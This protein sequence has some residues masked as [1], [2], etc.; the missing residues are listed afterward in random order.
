MLIKIPSTT[1]INSSYALYNIEFYEDEKL[2]D[3]KVLRMSKRFSDF[4]EFKKNLENSVSKRIDAEFPS[5]LYF[6]SSIDSQ[7]LEDRRVQLENFLNHILNDTAL[8]NNDILRNFLNLPYSSLISF[9]PGE[10]LNERSKSL[11][12]HSWNTIYDD[13]VN[14]NMKNLSAKEWLDMVRDVKLLIQ[15]CRSKLFENMNDNSSDTDSNNLNNIK[16]TSNLKLVECRK[17]LAAI[18]FR[19]EILNKNLNNPNFK[20]QLGKG[21]VIRRQDLF[22]SLNRDY[23]DMNALLVSISTN[24]K[25]TKDNN[26]MNASSNGDKSDRSNL[27]SSSTRPSRRTL[28]KPRETEVTKTMDNSELHQY[29]QQ[30]MQS[31]DEDLIV[32]RK[33]IERQRQIGHAINEELNI[34]NEILDGFNSQVDESSRKITYA[35]KKISK[36]V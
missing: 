25:N 12:T 24:S 6:K 36:I 9:K 1:V 17:N 22:N 30:T 20:N 29:Q 15:D 19:L 33:I 31:Q 3:S 7:V 27:F 5:K 23:K 32:L 18:N 16:N 35:K 14:N 8:R 11:K 28:G 10:S 34:Q 4:I 2:N 26:A 13:E 21:E